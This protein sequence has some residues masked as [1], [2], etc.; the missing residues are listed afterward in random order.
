MS[1]LT[2]LFPLYP[3]SRYDPS[4]V[5][6]FTP[7]G[8]ASESGHADA[9]GTCVFVCVRMYM[10]IYIYVYVVHLL[11][12]LLVSTCPSLCFFCL[13]HSLTHIPSLPSQMSFSQAL[14]RH[15]RLAVV[16]IGLVVLMV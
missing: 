4:R 3:Y 13:N 8:P 1:S 10:Y 16:M 7:D 5:P 9:T 14:H 15:H 11:V 6:I 2:P 12:P